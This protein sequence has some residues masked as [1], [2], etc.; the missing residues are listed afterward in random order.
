MGRPRRQR[1]PD[2]ASDW[3]PVRGWSR[4]FGLV[5]TCRAIG[6]I[7]R[8]DYGANRLGDEVTGRD[9]T[10]RS[11]RPHTQSARGSAVMCAGVTYRLPPL[12][13]RR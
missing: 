1:A 2:P 4:P 11:R 7:R 9:S 10:Y 8:R 12:R 13:A 3:G 5:R 6:I